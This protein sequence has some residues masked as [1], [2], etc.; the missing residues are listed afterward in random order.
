MK[1]IANMNANN[2][3]KVDCKLYICSYCVFVVN[4]KLIF[5][6]GF[7]S[8]NG[9]NLHKMTT[10]KDSRSRLKH[11]CEVCGVAY[12]HYGTLKVCLVFKRLNPSYYYL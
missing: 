9:L 12:L 11:I 4:E 5:D 10:H 7:S 6:L 3:I 1:I 2:V 8:V